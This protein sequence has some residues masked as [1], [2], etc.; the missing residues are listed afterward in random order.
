MGYRL[1]WTEAPWGWA[2][3]PRSKEGILLSCISHMR[4][5]VTPTRSSRRSILLVSEPGGRQNASVGSGWIKKRKLP[6]ERRQKSITGQI[7]PE[8]GDTH[9]KRRL[10]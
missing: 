1:P 8:D 5:G 3:N 7:G 6:A 2:P 4:N 10:T 9:V